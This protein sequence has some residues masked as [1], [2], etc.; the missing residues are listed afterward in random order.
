MQQ[1]LGI[2]IAASLA[3]LSAAAAPA[4]G[5]GLNVTARSPE[6]NTMA[7]VG[8]TISITFDKPLV[9]G[10]VTSSTFRVFG[11]G[12]GTKTGV[13]SFENSDMTVKL[14]PSTPFSAGEVVLVNLANTITA[15]DTSTLQSGG[16][17]YQFVVQTQTASM[18]FVE[19]DEMTNRIDNAQTRIYGAMATDLNHGAV[20]QDR[21]PHRQAVH[22]QS[23]NRTGYPDYRLRL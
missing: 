6:R 1:R 7:P 16:Y 11:R 5:A 23:S 2:A 3:V 21:V 14:T 22:H 9:T 13:I 19:I 4:A 17:A 15:T 12:T 8:A 10:S 20:R 18:S